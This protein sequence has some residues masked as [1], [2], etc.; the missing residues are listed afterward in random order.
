VSTRTFDPARVM[1]MVFQ[2]S[3]YWEG[4]LDAGLRDAGVT[5]KQL[6]LLSLLEREFHGPA[7]A[8]V[9]AGKMLTSHQN[10]MQMAR[11]LERG[12]FVT[13]QPDPADRRGRLIALTAEHR[14]YWE[15][16][17]R[18]DRKALEEVFAEVSVESRLQFEDLLETILPLAA[19]RYR[20]RYEPAG[21]L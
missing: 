19:E 15:S 11:A 8:S 10:I 17:A 1:R 4:I 5:A 3:R 7:R 14:E 21:E 20:N 13:I 6:F 2:L 16:R 18:R 9:I 12:G